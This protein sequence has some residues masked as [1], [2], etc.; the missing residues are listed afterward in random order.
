MAAVA[1]NAA[2]D[3]MKDDQG[4]SMFMLINQWGIISGRELFYAW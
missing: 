3:A 4:E 2:D 1:A